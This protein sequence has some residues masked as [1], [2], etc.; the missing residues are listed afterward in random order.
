MNNY[1][2]TFGSM[3]KIA[4]FVNYIRVSKVHAMPCTEWCPAGKFCIDMFNRMKYRVSC[5]ETMIAWLK[6]KA[7]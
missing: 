3:S 1:E 4:D 5:E 6:E 2:K 7:N